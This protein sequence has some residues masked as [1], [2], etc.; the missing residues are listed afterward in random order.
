MLNKTGYGLVVGLFCVMAV[1]IFSNG[2]E[3]DHPWDHE[4]VLRLSCFLVVLMLLVAW[5]WGMPRRQNIARRLRWPPNFG[6]FL[7]N[8]VVLSLLP[9]TAVTTAYFSIEHQFGL[10]VWLKMPLWLSVLLSL[11]VLDAAIYW[12]HRLFH[13][14]TPLWRVH[15][16]HHTDLEFD[17]TTALRFHP[18]EIVVSM[19]I[20]AV[21]ILL[22]GAP[23]VSVIAFEIILNSSAMFN[24]SNIRLPRSVDK[25]L[26]SV[27]VTPDMH[28]VHHSV[29]SSEHQ[30][31][32]GF[33]LSVWDKIFGSYVE[34][35]GAGHEQ[36]EIGLREFRGLNEGRWDKLL[37]QP[38]R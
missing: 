20:K 12:Q 7:I 34:Q 24:H 15:R 25:Y 29:H 19:F 31:N 3:W 4:S 35:P 9:L 1:L 30:F 26:R 2:R 5:E 10:F 21:V 22:L 28:R 17:V 27:V 8:I 36:M 18:V 33:C 16:M 14:I 37:T 32:F 6:V 23:I 13:L 38:F 11:L